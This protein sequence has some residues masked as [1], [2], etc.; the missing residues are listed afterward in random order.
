MQICEYKGSS[1]QHFEF[2]FHLLL[3]LTQKKV[4]DEKR[5]KAAN[6]N[7]LKIVSS[8]FFQRKSKVK[9]TFSNHFLAFLN[10]PKNCSDLE[11]HCSF[12]VLHLEKLEKK[13]FQVGKQNVLFGK[14]FPFGTIISPIFR[15]EKTGKV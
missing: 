12:D 15:H 9:P 11:F 6:S 8:I 4:M 3:V 2:E 5:F 14:I 10:T 7:R 13:K 1:Y